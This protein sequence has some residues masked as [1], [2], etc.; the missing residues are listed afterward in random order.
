MCV[1]CMDAEGVWDHPPGAPLPSMVAE[2]P[3]RLSWLWS[4]RLSP[5][6]LDAGP[7]HR[8]TPPTGQCSQWRVVGGGHRGHGAR[9]AAG[10]SCEALAGS[11][12]LARMKAVRLGHPHPQGRAS[13]QFSGQRA[14]CL[15]GEL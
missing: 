3:L 12:R 13:S 1:A 14:G 9:G 10:G 6:P 11:R 15:A 5:V 7:R 4:C 8:G 2:G